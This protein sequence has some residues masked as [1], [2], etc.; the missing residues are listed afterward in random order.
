[1]RH[2]HQASVP[3]TQHLPPTLQEKSCVCRMQQAA[4]FQARNV[5]KQPFWF[6]TLCSLEMVSDAH[7]HTMWA[8]HLNDL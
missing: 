3:H 5:R 8:G 2:K 4:A 7:M 1:M 6:L